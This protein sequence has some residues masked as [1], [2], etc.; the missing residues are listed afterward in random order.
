MRLQLEKELELELE[1]ETEIETKTSFD[2][3]SQAHAPSK[4]THLWAWTLTLWR[5]RDSI[6]TSWPLCCST[7]A[8]YRSAG[9]CQRWILW[10]RWVPPSWGLSLSLLLLLLGEGIV[11]IRI[12]QFNVKCK[13]HGNEHSKSKLCPGEGARK[14]AGRRSRWRQ[15]GKR[16]SSRRRG[17]RKADKKKTFR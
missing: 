3:H 15:M 11:S 1:T 7:T 10:I 2:F 14:E 4:A 8:P 12:R 6:A 16:G 17:V 9:E 5:A 13:T